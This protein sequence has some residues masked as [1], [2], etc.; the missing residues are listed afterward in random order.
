MALLYLFL[1]GLLRIRAA[2]PV[3]LPGVRLEKSDHLLVNGFIGSMILTTFRLLGSISTLI[4]ER[5]VQVP[6]N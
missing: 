6:E 2:G 5:D 3:I 1:K 4:H